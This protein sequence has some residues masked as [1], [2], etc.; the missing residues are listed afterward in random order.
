M[1]VAEQWG[2]RRKELKVSAYV[3]SNSAFI[4]APTIFT[5][6]TLFSAS[7]KTPTHTQ[8]TSPFSLMQRTRTTRTIAKLFPRGSAR[9]ERFS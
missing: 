8:C 3:Y 1:R 5:L 4:F 6:I 7:H 2:K 9:I